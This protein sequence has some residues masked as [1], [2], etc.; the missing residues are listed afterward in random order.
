MLREG[1][2]RERKL[3]SCAGGDERKRV[4]VSVKITKECVTHAV[5]WS[6]RA[7]DCFLILALLELLVTRRE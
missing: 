5:M 6:G 3:L 4:S 2:R 1:R 7:R